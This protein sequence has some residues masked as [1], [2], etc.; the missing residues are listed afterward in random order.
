M[1]LLE[2]KASFDCS[3]DA[4]FKVVLWRWERGRLWGNLKEWV[5]DLQHVRGNEVWC[6]V[7]V[8]VEDI[9]E[10]V[11]T[12]PLLRLFQL[13][14]FLTVKSYRRALHG[15]L[16][17]RL[18]RVLKVHF[19]RQLLLAGCKGLIH[20]CLM[21]LLIGEISFRLDLTI[22]ATLIHGHSLL[23]LLAWFCGMQAIDDSLNTL[24]VDP[25]VLW[26]RIRYALWF[27]EERLTMALFQVPNGSFEG[28]VISV[29]HGVVGTSRKHVGDSAPLVTEFRMSGEDR[30]VF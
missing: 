29:F 30:A 12:E 17:M 5:L 3:S 24:S 28:R 10:R 6:R 2:R 1:F 16:H 22:L 25:V 23:I 19:K 21:L 20:R 14:E 15:G 26:W 4:W 18:N 7:L 13:N 9:T 27:Q 11:G 8:I